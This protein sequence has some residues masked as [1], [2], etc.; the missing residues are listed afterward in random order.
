M[1]LGLL[2]AMPCWGQM[3]E[4][5]VILGGE[6]EKPVVTA[7]Y[8]P[9]EVEIGVGGVMMLRIRASAVGYSPVQRGRIVDAR[10]VYAL[11]YGNLDPEAVHVSMVR[12]QPTVYV[13]NIRLITVYDSDVEATGADSACELANLWAASVACCLRSLAPWARVAR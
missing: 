11:S 13:G 4:E 6:D 1:V 7:R 3:D 2:L 8:M 9:D 12:G 5:V 10:M